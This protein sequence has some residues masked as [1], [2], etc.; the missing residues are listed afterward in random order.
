MYSLQNIKEYLIFRIDLRR[1]I[2]RGRQG[3]THNAHATPAAILTG[4]FD[5]DSWAT[6]EFKYTNN[7]G[8]AIQPLG[9]VF[10]KVTNVSRASKASNTSQTKQ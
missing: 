3:T 1:E 5:F 6:D 10:S 9:C 7:I 8:S 4:Y 2:A